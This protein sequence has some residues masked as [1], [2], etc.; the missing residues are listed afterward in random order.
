MADPREDI[1]VRLLAVA[2]AI[3]GV[4]STARND[5]DFG[6]LNRPSM[7]IF[8]GDEQAEDADP[9]RSRPA[10]SPR[11]VTMTPQIVIAVGDDAE[12][13][14]STING[15]RAALIKAVLTDATLQN[16]TASNR[17]AGLWYEGSSTELGRGRTMEA[18]MT[19][20]FSFQYILYPDA[21]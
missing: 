2:T 6:E 14:G 10:N 20:A 21:L 19:V 11:R 8:E 1:L 16:L 4:N 3:P 13:V 7:T 17:G 9:V 12:T 15:L 18:E 5:P